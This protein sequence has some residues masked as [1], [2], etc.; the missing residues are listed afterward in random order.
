MDLSQKIALLESKLDH[1]ET[2]REELQRLLILFGFEKGI[3]SLKE[4]LKETILL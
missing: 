4:A 2:E 3:E 1:L